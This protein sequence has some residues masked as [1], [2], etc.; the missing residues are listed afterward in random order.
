MGMASPKCIHSFFFTTEINKEKTQTYIILAATLVIASYL[1]ANLSGSQSQPTVEMFLFEA[2]L[3]GLAEEIVFR[4]ILFSLLFCYSRYPRHPY[5]R[6]DAVIVI[7]VT[8]GYFAISHIL[9]FSF[10]QG[11][12][13]TWEPYIYFYSFI[14]GIILAVIRLLSKN[15]MIPIITH[16]LAN[17][18]SM[19]GSF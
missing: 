17:L 7:L 18:A 9:A 14:I 4:G 8:S 12:I 6:L 10:A 2:T 16:N 13:V 15:L 19:I 3:P 1:L 5:R 11:F